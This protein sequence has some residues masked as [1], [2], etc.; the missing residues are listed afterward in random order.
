[1][2][3][4]S[5]KEVA[6]C[7]FAIF[8]DILGFGLVAPL[9]VAIF[10]S[11]ES[12]IFAIASSSL[13]YL[14]LGV[15]LALYP[16][17][18]FFGTS[19]IGDLSDVI[20]R[21]KTLLFSMIGMAFSFVL[22]SIGIVASSLTLF[23][24]GRGLSGLVSASQSVALA[25]ISD[26]STKDNKAIHLSYV[27][28]IQ[29]IGFVVGPLMGGVLS[30]TTFYAPFLWAALFAFLAFLWIAFSFEETF[31]KRSDKRISIM[32]FLNVFTEAY[33]NKR[34]RELGFVFLLMQI[35]VGLY[36]PIIL[37]LLT[38]EFGYKPLFL[39]LFNGYMGAGF[40]VG[41][42]LVLPQMLKRLK[43]EQ[44][45]CISL[46]T[47]FL[48]QFF[49]SIFHAQVLIWLLA[50]PFAIAVEIA[51]SG[52]FTSFSN[53]ADERSQ[54]WV[55]GISVAIMAIAWAVAGFSAQLVPIFGVHTLVFI[56]SLFLVASGLF[57]KKY[58]SNHPI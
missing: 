56:G 57:M 44:I 9:L 24:L 13:R 28:L 18:M 15:T 19:F 36:L 25:T 49:S 3:K 4:F 33:Q 48:A 43:I 8:I 20:G 12:N 41:L 40:A 26:L 52:M 35:G 42:L 32:R 34:I 54:G 1:M 47:T 22:M 37:I 39:G 45:V 58:C 17:L 50:F 30:G 23:L 7:L 6:P 51:F 14:C 2:A 55:M 29:C 31:T 10:T 5:F 53:A 46:F 16:L 27:A 38:T 11:P 21:K